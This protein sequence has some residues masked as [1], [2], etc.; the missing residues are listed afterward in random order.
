[1]RGEKIV[2]HPDIEIYWPEK[3]SYIGFLLAAVVVIL[4][5]AGTMLLAKA[6]A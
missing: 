5:I 1:M 2:N 6:G 3:V 4:V